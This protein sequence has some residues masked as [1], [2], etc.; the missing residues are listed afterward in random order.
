MYHLPNNI[1]AINTPKQMV[2][3]SRITLSSSRIPFIS[4][5]QRIFLIEL[6]SGTPGININDID[7]S[8]AIISVVKPIHTVK[9]N[10]PSSQTY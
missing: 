1:Y 4:L 10:M 7:V 2:S 5:P 8:I 6:T 3:V 9:K